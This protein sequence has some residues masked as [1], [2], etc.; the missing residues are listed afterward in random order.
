MPRSHIAGLVAVTTRQ[1]FWK[2]RRLYIFLHDLTPES[3]ASLARSRWRDAIADKMIRMTGRPHLT[4]MQTYLSMPIPELLREI[5]RHYPAQFNEHNI[6][7]V[8]DG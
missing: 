4:I 8:A 6:V 5:E 3:R 1:A 7:V 2:Q